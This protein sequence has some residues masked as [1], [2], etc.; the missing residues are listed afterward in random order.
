MCEQGTRNVVD[1]RFLQIDVTCVDTL[2][3]RR[4]DEIV[5]DDLLDAILFRGR[6]GERNKKIDVQHD[7][8]RCGTFRRLDADARVHHH[9]AHENTPAVCEARG[10]QDAHRGSVVNITSRL[11]GTRCWPPST[12]SVAPVTATAFARY[13]TASPTSSR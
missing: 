13:T 9:L 10:Q 12:N 1:E 4:A 11:L 5:V 8:L 7:P 6:K 3:D 2:S